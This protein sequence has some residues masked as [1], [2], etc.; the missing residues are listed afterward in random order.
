MSTLHSVGDPGETVESNR[1]DPDPA[2][3][4]DS[5]QTGGFELDSVARR[6][7]GGPLQCL[8][9]GIMMLEGGANDGGDRA[10]NDGAIVDVLRQGAREM[11]EII[12][13]LHAAATTN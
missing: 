11:N 10:A 9:A 7:H 12:E 1:Q 6:L 3:S 2:G 13:A 5:A 8:F 4:A